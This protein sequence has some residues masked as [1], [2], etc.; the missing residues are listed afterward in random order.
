MEQTKPINVRVHG[1]ELIE[2]TLFSGLVSESDLFNFD[3]K[4]QCVADDD[5][6][7]IVTFVSVETKKQSDGLVLSKI[8]IG[9]GC[10][11]DNFEEAF[12]TGEND[13]RSLR[14][15]IETMLKQVAIS[16]MRGIMFSEF[17]GTQLHRATLPIVMVDQM[18]K[19]EGD[20]MEYNN[21]K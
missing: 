13:I 18:N 20:I 21:E 14:K 17:R 10:Y 4:A 16:T 8:L 5:N 2:K 1:I 11:I 12:I 19:V 15:D 6:K 7:V 9:V 3:I